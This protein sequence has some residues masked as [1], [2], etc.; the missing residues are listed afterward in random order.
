MHLNSPTRPP[1]EPWVKPVDEQ[2][3]DLAQQNLGEVAHVVRP[4][5]GEFDLSGFDNVVDA[6]VAV[7]TRHP[8]SEEELI[9][10]LDRWQ[11]GHIRE[12]LAELAK[13]G[14]AQVVVRGEQ[15]SWSCAEARYVEP[16]PA[17]CQENSLHIQGVQS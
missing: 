13:S 6:I 1:C 8:V 7:I 2:V 11:P 5:V 15:R 9:S 14:K 17:R 10:M 3:L 4:A 12:S 16:T